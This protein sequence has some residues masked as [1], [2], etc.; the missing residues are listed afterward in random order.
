MSRKAAKPIEF[1]NSVNIEF[2]EHL[3]NVKGP[4]GELSV[5]IEPGLELKIEDKK[6]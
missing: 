5:K 4:K 6:Y 1:D 2:K 3:L